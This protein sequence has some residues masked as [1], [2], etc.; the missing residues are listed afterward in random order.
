MV[1]ARS[2]DEYIFSFIYAIRLE[3]QL[4]IDIDAGWFITIF[5]M[6]YMILLFILID[7]RRLCQPTALLA[8]PT[9]P[10]PVIF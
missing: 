6:R 4:F 2:A 7:K 10:R 8:G 5:I 9:R 1:P 3:G